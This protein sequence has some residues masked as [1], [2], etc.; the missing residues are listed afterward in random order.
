MTRR[1]A[2]KRTALIM[3]YA[4][5][6]TATMGVL[7][8]CSADPAEKGWQPAFFDKE[9]IQLVAE[10][11]EQIL[12][13]T[14]TP[15]AKEVLVHRFMDQMLNDCY[16]PELQQRFTEGLKGFS[17]ECV[18]TYKRPFRK[19]SSEQQRQILTKY[20][21]A[22]YAMKAQIKAEQ[23]AE[24]AIFL[25]KE[26]ETQV[27]NGYLLTN[28]DPFFTM[29]KELTLLGYFTSTKVGTEI[30]NYDPIPGNY[31]GCIPLPE[32]GRGWSL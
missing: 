4:V 1:D 16:I 6:A 22:A 3:G 28:R 25:E 27:G 23:K 15:G 30:L 24:K 19:C 17:E 20:D 32:N 8:G 13:A 21:E 18:K 10:M 26:K 14:D 11:A 9:Q 29:F 2:I 5:S 31:D 7:N 12:P